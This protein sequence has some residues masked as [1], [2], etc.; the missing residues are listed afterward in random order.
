MSKG[1]LVALA[2]LVVLVGTILFHFLSPWWWTPIASNWEYIDHTIIV[3]F[4]ITGVVFVI[5]LAFMAYCIYRFSYQKN[6]RSEYDPESPR[7]ELWEKRP[8]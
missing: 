1:P 4:W 5:V 3:T 6:R 8:D 2:V 7:L